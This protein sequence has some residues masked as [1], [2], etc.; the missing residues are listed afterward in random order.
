MTVIISLLRSSTRH[1][2]SHC[3]SLS[4]YPLSPM[5]MYQVPLI[6]KQN[7]LYCP[8]TSS[9][10]YLATLHNKLFTSRSASDAS[11]DSNSLSSFAR[12]IDYH[13]FGM[14]EYRSSYY[15]QDQ[16]L[17]NGRSQQNYISPPAYSPPSWERQNLPMYTP[18]AVNSN[19]Y[20]SPNVL[21]H[22]SFRG[23]KRQRSTP[24]SDPF[25]D[26]RG[27]VK[28]GRSSESFHDSS[29]DLSGKGQKIFGSSFLYESSALGS[30]CIPVQLPIQAGPKYEDREGN[31]LCRIQT[32]E[33]G[34]SQLVCYLTLRN[35]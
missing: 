21:D 1:H 33:G 25:A 27:P 23:L 3:P 15:N 18:K 8:D 9:K 12:I 31:L 19:L 28:R 16:R 30:G 35:I 7:P 6:D 20:T 4:L 29:F 10:T 32:L 24:S 17:E 26:L 13:F 34:Y 14:V 5:S 22:L 11:D 2:L